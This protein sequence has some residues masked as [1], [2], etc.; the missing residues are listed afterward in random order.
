MENQKSIILASA[1]PRRKELMQKWGYDFTVVP[2]QIDEASYGCENIEPAEYAKKLAEAKAMDVASKFPQNLTIG[3][4][5]IVDLEGEIIGKPENSKHAREITTK[6]FS[7]PHKVI[8][9]L[10]IIRLCDSTKI[11]QS[12]TTVV[13]PRKMSLQQI[14]SH[15]Q[16]GNW[17]GK[18]GAYGIQETGDEFVEKIEGSF[19][20]VMGM[21]MEMLE[22]LLKG[23]GYGK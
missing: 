8:T 1:S 6:L 16:S 23:I 15:I 4:D 12:D 11:I 22:R 14:E 3:A 17:Q 5:T 20:N 13:Y 18:A 21:P 10:A 9:A 7:C 2:A 19:T